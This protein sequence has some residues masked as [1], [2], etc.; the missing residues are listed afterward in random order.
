MRKK[1]GVR[2]Y[3]FSETNKND[4]DTEHFYDSTGFTLILAGLK[5]WM[6]VSNIGVAYTALLVSFAL[7]ILD[8]IVVEC[9]TQRRMFRELRSS[10]EQMWGNERRVSPEHDHEVN[11]YR[12]TVRMT[13]QYPKHIIAMGA[14][15]IV[16]SIIGV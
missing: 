7:L 5:R 4:N 14:G 6:P 16:L 11:L 10:I 8:V 12:G 9:S 2:W 13:Q 15:M 1:S 3:V